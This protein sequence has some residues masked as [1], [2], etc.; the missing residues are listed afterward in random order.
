MPGEYVVAE[1]SGVLY[2]LLSLKSPAASALANAAVGGVVVV[3]VGVAA[4]E[5]L[6]VGVEFVF[7]LQDR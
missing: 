3:G 4:V 5:C 6:A 1:L 2:L 7:D